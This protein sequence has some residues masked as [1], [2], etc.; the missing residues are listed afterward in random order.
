MLIS[1]LTPGKSV[2]TRRP[3]AATSARDAKSASTPCSDSSPV[4]ASG[5]W[6]HAGGDQIVLARQCRIVVIDLVGIVRPEC[7]PDPLQRWHL[8][9]GR[10]VDVLILLVVVIKQ[11]ATIGLVRKTPGFARLALEC[12]RFIVGLVEGQVASG[13]DCRKY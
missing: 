10:T 7:L 8:R 2:R 1:T 12:A 4:A 13:D 6:G 5:C 11:E 9:K 3:S